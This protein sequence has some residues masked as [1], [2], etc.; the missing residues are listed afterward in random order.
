[1]PAIFISYRKKDAG[2][3]VG[4]LRS[5]LER[6]YGRK[7]VFTDFDS[8]KPGSD[9]MAEIEAALT[10][11]D[12]ALVVIG[13]NWLTS[14]V[15]SAGGERVRRIDEEHDVLR[16]E[17][18]AALRHPGVEVVPLL[19]EDAKP[20]NEADL[21][22]ELKELSGLHVCYLRNREWKADFAEIR[23]TI[24]AAAG[25]SVTSRYLAKARIA[26]GRHLAVFAALL[27]VVLAAAL[28]MALAFDGGSGEGCEN[29]DIPTD[30]RAQLPEAAGT[31]A[32]AEFGVY[33]GTCGSQSWAIAEF[34]D[35]P[36]NVFVQEGFGWRRL[37]PTGA[38]KCDEVP[39][40]L[41]DDWKQ[42]DC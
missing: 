41:L 42:N 4:H 32:E 9:W 16:K 36:S 23:R 24:E 5:D 17:I 30:V 10:S 13:E 8:I 37:G 15:E 33:Y 39:P 27:A 35:V 29:L 2:G 1:M 6:T 21:P 19:V 31:S 18:S 20:L 28:A 25:D 14:D 26:I 38:T 3:H 22:E 12:V 11:S 40:E 7:A 34:P